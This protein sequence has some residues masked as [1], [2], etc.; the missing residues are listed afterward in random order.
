MEKKE[1]IIVIDGTSLA[2]RAFYAMP[3]LTTSG[4]RPT[5][6]TLGFLNM[7]M[8]LIE[9]YRPFAILVVFDH[10][11]KTFRHVLEERYKVS[12][13]PM[14]DI[15]RPQ[16]ED[17]KEILSYLGFPIFEVPGFEGDDLIGS[18]KERLGGQYA[19]WV[20][21]SDF[22]LL[23]LLD[24]DTV[25]LKPIQGVTRLRK[26]HSQD[27]EEELGISPSQVVDLLALSGDVSDD[28]EGVEGVGEKKAI[29]LLQKFEN[30]EGIFAHLEVLSPSLRESILRHRERIETNKVLVTVRKDIPLDVAVEPWDFARVDWPQLERKLEEL[31]LRKFWERI[32]QK[33]KDI[34]L[35]VL[36]GN[37]LLSFDESNPSKLR[38]FSSG[39]EQ[40]FLF[41]V[42]DIEPSSF[43]DIW[44][45]PSL[46]V[47]PLFLF[48][49]YPCIFPW[50]VVLSLL[51]GHL[52]SL[53]WKELRSFAGKAYK[54]VV[55]QASLS[56]VYRNVELVILGKVLLGELRF[57][58]RA[59]ESLPLFT[60]SPCAFS[61]D[62][63]SL[64]EAF[65][66]GVEKGEC[67]VEEG[68]VTF[69]TLYGRRYIGKEGTSEKELYRK[70]EAL[71]EEEFF[72]LVARFVGEG[73]VRLFSMGREGLLVEQP[74][75]EDSLRIL[76]KVLRES[77]QRRARLEED[78][79]NGKYTLFLDSGEG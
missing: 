29:Q 61:V 18:L 11:Q 13:K 79:E 73:N 69:P 57:E 25:L 2:Y 65:L 36:Q 52:G 64:R 68:F 21:S 28:I 27:L 1:V 53:S 17:I 16:L 70:Y 75:G 67:V 35:L 14:P 15:L 12:R 20:V 47:A 34:P 51:Q 32:R 63:E 8:R 3:R 39:G 44:S 31:E 26:I 5:G 7:V 19:L 43:W 40:A 30:L 42:R 66:R 76:K 55:N 6:A 23:Q 22:D 50:S 77:L 59:L 45:T 49:A 60:F 74:P 46:C 24:K 38:E 62:R 33:R 56:W 10:P 72:H 37:R 58:K 41:S 71:F 4:G 48:L 78:R 54:Q 9:D